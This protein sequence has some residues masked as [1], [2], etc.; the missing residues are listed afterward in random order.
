MYKMY[1]NVYNVLKNINVCFVF[2]RTAPRHVPPMGRWLLEWAIR[3]AARH[4]TSIVLV[5]ATVQT[6]PHAFNVPV[7]TIADKVN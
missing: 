1:E 7:V 5:A 2:L 3:V 6:P 4:K